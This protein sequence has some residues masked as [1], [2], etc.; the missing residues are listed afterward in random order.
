MIVKKARSGKNGSEALLQPS[1]TKRRELLVF[2]TA[3]FK[4]ANSVNVIVYYHGH[5]VGKTENF[6]EFR[7]HY[8]SSELIAAVQDAGKALALVVPDLGANADG[9]DWTSSDKAAFDSLIKDTLLIA[10]YRSNELRS[11]N[12]L[13]DPS[14]DFQTGKK[15]E[16]LEL[17]ALIL[18]AHSGGGFAMRRVRDLGSGHAKN[19]KEVWMLDSLY[20]DAKRWVSW[21][22]LS[23]VA[24]HNIYTK[25]PDSMHAP[26]LNSSKIYEPA[27][28]GEAMLIKD[29]PPVEPPNNYL[30]PAI[31]SSVNHHHVPGK[32]IGGL[33]RKSSNL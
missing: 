6:K 19:L 27:R 22:A 10:A 18:A 16:P 11:G 2:L 24:V 28:K 20:D 13:E 12:T 23:G 31:E 26:Y 9:G 14:K 30:R 7:D 33:I 17:G 1:A 32:F 25:G 5:Y 3:S 15:V 29:P 21:A 4:P 8:T